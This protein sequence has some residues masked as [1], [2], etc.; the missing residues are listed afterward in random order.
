M[1]VAVSIDIPQVV[2]LLILCYVNVYLELTCSSMYRF[3]RTAHSNF[4]QLAS[5]VHCDMEWSPWYEPVI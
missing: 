4:L 5:I 3:T 2:S 1:V